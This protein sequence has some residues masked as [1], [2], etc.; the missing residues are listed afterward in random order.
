MC[1]YLVHIDQKTKQNVTINMK[2]YPNAPTFDTVHVAIREDGYLWE[3]F[4]N[5]PQARNAVD[6]GTAHALAILFRAFEE[7]SKARVAILGGIGSHFCAGADLKAV[8][9]GNPNDVYP[10]GEAEGPMGPTRMKLTKPVIAA[11]QGS[12]VAGGLELACWADLRVVGTGSQL[13]VLC[14]RWGVPLIDG[15]TFRLPKLIGQSHALDLILTGRMI[16]AEEAYRM[17]LANR[18]VDDDNVQYEA[19]ELA[20][21]LIDLYVIYIL[22]HCCCQQ[23]NDALFIIAVVVLYLSENAVLNFV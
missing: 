15:G 10:V 18:L 4:I 17:G 9:Q 8:A 20:K 2:Y 22:F 11:I 21:H 16:S 23:D 5:R 1:V 19:R 7:D 12:C 3:I 14:R 6:R 13:G